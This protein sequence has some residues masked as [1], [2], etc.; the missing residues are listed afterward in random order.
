M[1]EFNIK[2]FDN[3]CENISEIFVQSRSYNDNRYIILLDA[4]Y[5][6]GF[7]NVTINLGKGGCFWQNR[8]CLVFRGWQAQNAS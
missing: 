3:N 2:V 7:E 5:E 8:K 4:N 6:Q 1:G